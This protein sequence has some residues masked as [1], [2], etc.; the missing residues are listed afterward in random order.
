[1]SAIS[2]LNVTNS[3]LLVM[4]LVHRSREKVLNVLFLPVQNTPLVRVKMPPSKIARTLY[5]R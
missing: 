4:K 1:M 2:G 5:C 3:K